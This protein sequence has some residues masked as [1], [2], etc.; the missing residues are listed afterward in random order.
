[1]K[2]ICPLT[3][4]CE[5]SQLQS[6]REVLLHDAV[7][8]LNVRVTRVPSPDE[9]LM[10]AGQNHRTT[11]SHVHS[12]HTPHISTTVPHQL[13]WGLSAHTLVSPTQAK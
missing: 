7:S 3:C 6:K 4:R 2:F 5:R 1:M 12:L 11:I 10:E 8:L 13:P 9:V